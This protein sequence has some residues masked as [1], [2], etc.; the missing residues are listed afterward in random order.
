MDTTDLRSLLDT[1]ERQAAEL[2]AT[3]GSAYSIAA[4]LKDTEAKR[5]LNTLHRRARLLTVAV[6]AVPVAPD[7]PAEKEIVLHLPSRPIITEP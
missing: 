2:R 7:P 6:H 1:A 4:L 5:R 3:I